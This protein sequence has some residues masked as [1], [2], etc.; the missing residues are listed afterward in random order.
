MSVR[1]LE[2]QNKHMQLC[3]VFIL[4]LILRLYRLAVF[5]ASFLFMKEYHIIHMVL[6]RCRHLLPLIQQLATIQLGMRRGE[7]RF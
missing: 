2:L 5:Q 1:L 3:V 4:M 6:L 7:H